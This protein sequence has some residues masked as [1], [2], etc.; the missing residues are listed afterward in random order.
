MFAAA[1]PLVGAAEERSGVVHAAIAQARSSH[2]TE[3]GVEVLLLDTRRREVSKLGLEPVG[4]DLSVPDQ[5]RVLETSIIS[6]EGKVGV[7]E[8]VDRRLA[9]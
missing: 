3:H 4:I 8:L 2:P 1:C 5:C 9:G 7:D 6:S